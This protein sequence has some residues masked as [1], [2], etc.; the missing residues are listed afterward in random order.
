MSDRFEPRRVQAEHLRASG[1]TRDVLVALVRRASATARG[2][3][4]FTNENESDRMNAAVLLRALL[5][6]QEQYLLRESF[7]LNARL[8]LSDQTYW[9]AA[10]LFIREYEM[11]E[12]MTF[13]EVLGD[14]SV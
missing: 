12:E 4:Y 6:D 2:D 10:N 1:F 9:I 5:V 13:E 11:G 3:W 8:G 14:R 7:I